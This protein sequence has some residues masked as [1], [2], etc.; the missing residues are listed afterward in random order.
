MLEFATDVGRNYLEIRIVVG[1]HKA[2]YPTTDDIFSTH[3][4]FPIFALL[5]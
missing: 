3:A 4:K 1:K 5:N 2:G